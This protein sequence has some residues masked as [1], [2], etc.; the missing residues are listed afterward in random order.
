ML[1]FQSK[2]FDII[3]YISKGTRAWQCF[4]HG[5]SSNSI[6][7]IF[8]PKFPQISFGKS[9]MDQKFHGPTFFIKTTVTKKLGGKFWISS[10]VHKR[11]T[12]PICKCSRIFL[13]ILDLL[14]EIQQQK[15][16]KKVLFNCHWHDYSTVTG[17]I[18][19]QSLA[20]LFNSY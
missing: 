4:C 16:Q 2:T 3:I 10:S 15:H 11:L 1:E 13:Y 9:H 19:H 8:I 5:I 12:Y 18:V 6:R 7:Q 20:Q 14:V 17:T